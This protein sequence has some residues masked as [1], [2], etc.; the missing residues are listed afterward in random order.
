MSHF[1]YL[2]NLYYWL[3]DAGYVGLSC[4]ITVAILGVGLYIGFGRSVRHVS[5]FMNWDYIARSSQRNWQ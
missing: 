4:C 5:G 2:G 1:V 3:V